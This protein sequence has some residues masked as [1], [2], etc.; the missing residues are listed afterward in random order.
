MGVARGSVTQNADSADGIVFRPLNSNCDWLLSRLIR[1]Q[2]G[3]ESRSSRRGVKGRGEV[4]ALV[5]AAV[6]AKLKGKNDRV[7]RI[8]DGWS[9]G[10]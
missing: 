8:T 7:T 1:T 10:R 3:N 9:D 6:T 2:R 5:D 4:G